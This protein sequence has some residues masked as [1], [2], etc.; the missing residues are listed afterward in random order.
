[1]KKKDFFKDLKQI[2]R[3]LENQ[4]QSIV[5]RTEEK[6]L[7]RGKRGPTLRS[8]YVLRAKVGI[9]DEQNKRQERE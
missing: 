6:K 4:D 2:I 1:M 3:D 7:G 9:Q 5:G 8:E